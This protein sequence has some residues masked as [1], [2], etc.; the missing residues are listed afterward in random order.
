MANKARNYSVVDDIAQMKPGL[1]D[2]QLLLGVSQSEVKR[3]VDEGIIK[4]DSRGNYDLLYSLKGYIGHLQVRAGS[5]SGVSADYGEERARLTKAQADKAE[6]EAS[7]LA[8]KLVDVDQLISQWEMMLT[9][10][11]TKML[12]IPSKLAPVIADEDEPGIIQNVIDDY[13]REALEELASYG[14][15]SGEEDTDE[16]DGGVETAT[17]ADSKPVGRPRKKAGRSI[18]Q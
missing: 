1:R 9:A 15:S 18:K 2:M 8:G 14:T 17:Q 4:K 16:R 11:K 3:L 5:R 10:V 7:V 12:A 13:V 6:M